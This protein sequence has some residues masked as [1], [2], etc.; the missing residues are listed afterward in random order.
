M[1]KNDTLTAIFV[2][3]IVALFGIY[4]S[5]GVDEGPVSWPFH[6]SE[7][8]DGNIVIT[9]T[10]VE[11]FDNGVFSFDYPCD[12][13]VSL[14]ESEDQLIELDHY[15]R[16][17]PGIGVSLDIGKGSPESYEGGMRL[18]ISEVM[19]TPFGET[20]GPKEESLSFNGETYPIKEYGSHGGITYVIDMGGMYAVFGSEFVLSEKSLSSIFTVLTSLN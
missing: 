10:C 7:A 9:N 13:A 17:P 19:T 3:L 18:N 8:W 14:S 16:S 11:K 15:D 20:Y 6:R 4:Y 5:Q 1:K 12:W 2:L